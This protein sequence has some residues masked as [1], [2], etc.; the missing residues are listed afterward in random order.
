MS[1][2]AF[3][4]QIARHTPGVVLSRFRRGP[5]RP[6]WSLDFELFTTAL[7]HTKLEVPR[8]DWKAL[9]ALFDGLGHPLPFLVQDSPSL[10][11]IHREE[12]KV[13][14]VPVTW[15]VPNT[16]GVT[17]SSAEVTLLYLHGGGYVFGSM[18][19]HGDLV[20]RLALAA[21]ARALAPEYRLAPEH[22][23]PAAID[24]VVAVY[25]ALLANGTEP[26][27]LVVGGD[28]AGGGLTLAL[29]QRLRDAGEPLPA[30]AVLISPWVDLTAKGGS[31]TENAAFDWMN[32]AIV[33]DWIETYLNGHDRRDPLVSPVYADLSGLPPL[34]IQVGGAELLDD[35]IHVLA[36]RAREHGVDARLVVEP[37]MIH[38]W[39][40]FASLFSQCGRAIDDVGAFVRSVT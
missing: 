34:L 24:D 22:P 21:P 10:R 7:R 12:T 5:S 18:A 1:R 35:Q 30:G 39:H 40:V 25:R 31:V 27:R 6:S 14:G 3:L 19:T 2:I 32:E 17:G 16:L 26:K 13:G 29:L 23:F 28:S 36:A 20:A 15:F 38:A 33:Q 11:R 8:R 4:R 9:R 37:D